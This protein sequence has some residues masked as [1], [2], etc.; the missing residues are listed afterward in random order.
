M[1]RGLRI[2]RLQHLLPEMGLDGCVLKGMDNIFYLTGFR[3]SEGMLLVTRGDVVLAVDFRY[4]T[5]AREATSGIHIYEIKPGNDALYTLCTKYKVSKLGFDGANVTYNTYHA[6]SENLP[7]ISLVPMNSS[8]DEMRKNK[9]AEEIAAIT[10][11]ISIATEAFS[12]IVGLIKPGETEKNIADELDH[13]MR[14]RGA[15]GPSFDTIVASGPRSALPHAEPTDRKLEKGET[16]ILDFGATVSG[17]CSDETVTLC[18]GEIPDKLA[19]IYTVVNDARKL[20][21]EK[22]VSGTP[23]KQL[24]SIVRGYIEEK[25]YGDHFRHGVGHGVGIAVHESP[26]INSSAK[27]ILEDNMVI[28]IEPGI[29]LPNIGGVRLEDMVLITEDTPR[30]L[31][32]I[33]KDII[34]I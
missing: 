34:K 13:M 15:Q 14:K 8:I 31:T 3:G 1:R 29:Y 11:A 30:I 18:L 26:A 27:G 9:E 19:E 7:G 28:T 24:D 25:G 22:A 16:V 2:E 12:D 6:W 23:I 33:R 5:H 32:H 21:I 20:G 17:Y 4:I 10:D